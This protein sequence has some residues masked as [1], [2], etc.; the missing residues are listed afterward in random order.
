M[1]SVYRDKQYRLSRTL[2][3]NLVNQDRLASLEG[4]IVRFARNGILAVVKTGEGEALLDIN[5]ALDYRL[6][7][8]DEIEV[9]E[10]G[11]YVSNGRIVTILGYRYRLNGLTHIIK[12]DDDL[13]R[14]ALAAAKAP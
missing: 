10:T 7:V 12:D 4:T 6:K 14:D 9:E 2:K 5:D 13:T 8:G 1:Y 3:G 11:W